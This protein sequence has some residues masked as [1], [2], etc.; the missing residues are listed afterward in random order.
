MATQMDD[1]PSERKKH[2]VMH[3][4]MVDAAHLH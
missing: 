2:F 1:S 4:A 3:V